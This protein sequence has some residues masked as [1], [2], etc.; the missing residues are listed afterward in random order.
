MIIDQP[1]T[2]DLAG[3]NGKAHPADVVGSAPSHD[4]IKIPPFLERKYDLEILRRGSEWPWEAIAALG[5]RERIVVEPEEVIGEGVSR[6][7]GMAVPVARSWRRDV[8]ML[9]VGTLLGGVIVVVFAGAGK[10]LPSAPNVNSGVPTATVPVVAM[11]S[12]TVIEVVPTAVV[13]PP[14]FTAEPL[15]TDTVEPTATEIVVVLPTDTA[16]EIPTDIPEPTR[17]VQPTR[18]PVRPTNT[19]V[20]A[21]VAT[22]TEEEV[23]TATPAPVEPTAT[24]EVAPTEGEATATSEPTEVATVGPVESPTPLPG[25]VTPTVEPISTPTE[26][27][28]LPTPLPGILTPTPEGQ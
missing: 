2:A 7:K 9:A 24:V 17:I 23:A 16:V 28:G 18:V 10:G 12:A 11:A 13:V 26:P 4:E 27:G 8:A 15:A 1:R 21:P 25:I 3:A 5:T 14:T 20:V 19:R 22:A 6:R